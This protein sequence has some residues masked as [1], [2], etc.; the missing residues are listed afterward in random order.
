[1]AKSYKLRIYEILEAINPDDRMAEAVNLIMLVLVVLNVAAVVLETVES[2][3]VIHKSLFHY[4]ADISV[5]IF[6]IEYLLRIW[7]C[8]VA[9][10]YRHPFFGRL[11]F[12]LTPLALVDL[13]VI[14]P[15]YAVLAFP[16]D[17]QLLRSLRLLWSFRLLKL[18]RYSESLRIIEDVIR[19]QQRELVMSFTAILFFLVLSSTV[20]FF[21]EHDAQPQRFPDIPATMWWAVLT[22]TTIGDNFYPITPLGKLVGG[23][24][25]ILGVATF[26]LPTAI[27]TSGFVEELERRRE[28]KD[29]QEPRRLEEGP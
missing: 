27:L 29:A 22:M 21:L 15:T 1:M 14:L 6:S 10:E 23:L 7:S 13:L 8:D 2:I 3:Y 9:P 18:R 17:H 20:V 26:A 11:Q 28:E 12:A 25:I 19:A 24:I 4:F 16:T 5:I